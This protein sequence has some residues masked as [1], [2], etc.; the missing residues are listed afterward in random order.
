M[1]IFSLFLLF[2]GLLLLP[3]YVHAQSS[4]TFTNAGGDNDWENSANWT[5]NGVPGQVDYD[6]VTILNGDTCI[7]YRN[8]IAKTISL[9]LLTVEE[10]AELRLTGGNDCSV[11]IY[12][13]LTCNGLVNFL[14]TATATMKKIALKEN[15]GN[16][17]NGAIVVGDLNVNVG[18]TLT[19]TGRY[20]AEEE[21]FD[22]TVSIHEFDD[23]WLG[24]T[25]VGY[26]T[27]DANWVSGAEPDSGYLAIVGGGKYPTLRNIA[28]EIE[29]T[30]S[31]MYLSTLL[32]IRKGSELT[33][34]DTLHNSGEILIKSDGEMAANLIYGT[35]IG[36]GTATISRY[37]PSANWHLVSSPVWGQGMQSFGAANYI[38][39]YD[40]GSGATYDIGVHSESSGNWSYPVLVSGTYT[41]TFEFGKGYAIRMVA[42]VGTG[43]VDISG[44]LPGAPSSTYT[45]SGLTSSNFGWECLGNPYTS[46]LDIAQFLSDNSSKINSSY[47]AVYLWD[48][49]LSDYKSATSGQMA[50][51][52]GFFVKVGSGTTSIGFNPAQRVMGSGAEFKSA[53]V[54]CPE[55]C[56]TAVSGDNINKTYFKFNNQMTAGL[57]EGNDLGKLKGNANIALFS[58]LLDDIGIDMET[59]ALPEI[60]TEAFRI[61]I[62]LD[63]E[64][65]GEVTF[66]VSCEN[67]PS[68]ANVVLEDEQASAKA[69]LNVEG[70]SY[71]ATV[72]EGA[73][74]TGRFYLTVGENTTGTTELEHP[75]IYVFAHNKKIYVN[76][77]IDGNT[78]IELF[79]S[80]GKLLYTTFAETASQNIIDASGL[81]TG[82]YLVKIGKGG[83]QVFK[84][85]LN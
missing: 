36:S 71:T 73:S 19:G 33:I 72:G 37:I 76:G 85:V 49:S 17:V 20:Y 60:S 29:R 35:A 52:Q 64:A 6:N 16:I 40:D 74:G 34:T 45:L 58:R 46:S 3:P 4:Y 80:D 67:M 61:P 8:S 32:Q 44:P 69:F 68:N 57:D 5:P 23:V 41:D 53:S 7:L 28:G 56:L 39:S 65:G 59:Q 26:W 1:K 25:D 12:G 70:G 18:A 79:N 43:T 31:G 30:Y 10:G 38:D 75:G 83:G 66:T 63:L 78:L 14:T 50:L 15:T 77:E 24:V 54:P 21:S 47:S 22:G 27:Q 13:G 2:G 48:Q 9:N 55:M 51:G 84:T 62:G 82:V 81:P 11:K 42:S